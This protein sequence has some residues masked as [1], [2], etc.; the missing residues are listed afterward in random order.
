MIQNARIQEKSFS[1][2]FLLLIRQKPEAPYCVRK[3]EELSSWGRER[4]SLS[5]KFSF[6]GL[7]LQQAHAGRR[8]TH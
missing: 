1:S 2:L 8:N 4:K 3:D 6:S 7:P 5:I